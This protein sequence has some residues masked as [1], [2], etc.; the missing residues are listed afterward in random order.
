MSQHR[1]HFASAG[2]L[3]AM[4]ARHTLVHMVFK[5]QPARF[6]QVLAQI[7]WDECLKILAASQL[8]NAKLGS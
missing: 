2:S 4:P 5:Q 1:L 7:G 3:N 8:V 6:G